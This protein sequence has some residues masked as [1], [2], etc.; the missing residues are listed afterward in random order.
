MEQQ[1]FKV[2]FI[3][4]R[5]REELPAHYVKNVS[6]AHEILA[7]LDR[8]PRSQIFGIDLETYPKPEYK[9]YAKAGLSPHLAN[10]RLMQVFT[11]KSVVVFDMLYLGKALSK[12]FK[13]F[14]TK[15]KFVAHNAKFELAHLTNWGAR[16][17]EIDC[18]FIMAKIVFHAARPTDVGL[19]AGLKELVEGLFGYNIL[20]SA[21]LSDWSEPNLTFEQVEYAALDAVCT[22]KVMEMLCKGLTKYDLSDYYKLCR[23]AQYPIVEMELNGS[24]FN[25]ERHR[26]M[27]E[28]WGHEL[29]GARKQLWK[30]TGLEKITAHTIAGYLAE[31]LDEETLA[32]WPRTETGKL[33]TDA[34]TFSEYDFL[35]IVVP[36]TRYQKLDKLTSAFGMR[37]ISQVNPA[38]KRL[39][40]S[41]NICGARTGRLSCSQPNLQ[42]LPNDL[43]VRKNFV[44]EPGW[45][46][47]VCDLSQIEL[48]V[49]AELT[50]DK[51][52][53][54]AF[55]TGIDIHTL[56]ASKVTGKK[57][58]DVSPTERK[59]G[60]Q[61]GLGLLYG[62]GGKKFGHYARKGGVKD[63]TDEEAIEA[64]QAF[65]EAY[66]GLRRWQLETTRRAGKTLSSRTPSGKSRKLDPDK[67]YGASLNTPCQG[68]A[69][70]VLLFSLIET[71]KRLIDEKLSARFV[72]CVHDETIIECP[73]EE[74]PLVKK[75]LEQAMKDGYRAVFPKGITH[76]IAKPTSGRTWGGAKEKK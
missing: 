3:T 40:A 15:R 57:M 55:R 19:R 71:R 11:G 9:A 8:Y 51:E 23:A 39:H 31:H 58:G 67:F 62:L 17:L 2:N 28:K 30:V 26:T 46:M 70:E 65:R 53:L 76:G 7:R 50:Q 42:Q 12:E 49:M 24:G 25:I 10:I 18:S 59:L 60:K 47:V 45:R 36:F 22:Y 63:I 72:S 4:K 68:A 6:D 35:K 29:Y 5:D 44:P 27:C 38:T 16:D 34:H 1:S 14:L 41:Y 32:L 54:R 37:L 64:V 13:K 61:L 66:P 56:T 75:I 43:D 33:K 52:M 21:Q 73:K 74:V 69:A 48:R 20:K